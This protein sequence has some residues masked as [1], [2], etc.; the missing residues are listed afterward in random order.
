MAVSGSMKWLDYLKA[1]LRTS[2]G[3]YLLAEIPG[4]LT[5][6]FIGAS[7]LG[8]LVAPVVLESVAVFILL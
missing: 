1:Y 4:L 6:L 7:S 3:E 2:R 5:V 8:R